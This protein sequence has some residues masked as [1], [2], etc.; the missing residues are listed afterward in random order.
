[1]NTKQI[2]LILALAAAALLLLTGGD[3]PA[4]CPGGNCQRV[5]YAYSYGY[6][7]WGG[8]FWPVY[9]MNYYQPNTAAAPEEPEPA[10]GA[11]EETPEEPETPALD[12]IPEWEPAGP[13]GDAPAADDAPAD[14]PGEAGPES[15]IDAEPESGAPSICPLAAAAIN[16]VNSARAGC[17][18]DP[19]TADPDLCAACE[20]HSAWMRARGFGHAP[21]GGRECIAENYATPA[22][23]V[24][25]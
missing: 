9:P 4:Q 2:T 24:S 23:T 5:G 15:G 17:G 13:D 25:A 1:M 14:G 7:G 11:A 19:L 22:A 10:G 8:W 20:R 3:A 21:D 18:L 12:E 6:Q 16:A